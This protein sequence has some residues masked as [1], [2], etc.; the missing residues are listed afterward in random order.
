MI[1]YLAEVNRHTRVLHRSNILINHCLVCGEQMGKEGR[2]KKALMVC[3]KSMCV[4]VR[5]RKGWGEGDKKGVMVYRVR[6]FRV[7]CC[8]KCFQDLKMLFPL[9]LRLFPPNTPC[10]L[11]LSCWMHRSLHFPKFTRCTSFLDELSQGSS[12]A[13]VKLWVCKL[14]C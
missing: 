14:A 7:Q 11:I 9:L 3:R 2:I 1:R 6:L 8:L 5:E 13:L 12:C 4:C 10:S